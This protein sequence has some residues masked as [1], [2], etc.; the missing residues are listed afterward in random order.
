MNYHTLTTPVVSVIVPL[1]NSI[2]FLEECLESIQKQR[3]EE[4]EIL[5]VDA[6]S[7]DGSVE[8]IEKY[9]E[10][11]ARFRLLRCKE[12]SYGQQVNLGIAAARGR[13]IGIVESDDYLALDH[14]WVLY[15]KAEALQPDFV[16]G[17]FVQF[18]GY[19]GSRVFEYLSRSNPM[20]EQC[21]NLKENPGYRLF[22]LLH[23]WSGIYRKDFLEEK[24]IQLN[25]TPGAS[26]Q[27][28]SFSLLVGLLADSGIYTRE[29]GY[30]YR[31]DN[32]NSSVKSDQKVNC[33]IDEYEYLEKT[34]IANGHLDE[35]TRRSIELYKLVSYFWNYRR[36]SR[37]GRVEFMENIHGELACLDHTQLDHTQQEIFEF[38]WDLKGLR[39]Y[40]EVE[41][42]LEREYELFAALVESGQKFH[43][44]T[45]GAMT[46]RLRHL[47]ETLNL[48]LEGGNE[49]ADILIIAKNPETCVRNLERQGEDPKKI[50][51][52]R[53]LPSFGWMVA[54]LKV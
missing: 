52:I 37:G 54:R 28:T 24:Q 33:I 4:I 30:F 49:E 34:L 13:Y 8:L 11:D 42:E 39:R 5:C 1:F 19:R 3:L 25:P 48:E 46:R 43:C 32:E 21:L 2:Q 35:G 51:V 7:R 40:E 44:R 17:G 15:Q 38:L 50:R 9:V 20:M 18:G 29:C 45:Q 36:M 31:I 53:Q 47:T 10:E 23:I 26:Y 14:Y 12:P 6:G 27:D 22:D 16:K 41:E